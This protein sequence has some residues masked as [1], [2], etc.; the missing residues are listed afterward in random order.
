MGGHKPYKKRDK[1]IV[2]VGIFLRGAATMS[3]NTGFNFQ[4]SKCHYRC[5]LIIHRSGTDNSFA[6]KCPHCQK[7]YKSGTKMSNEKEDKE[8]N[9]QRRLYEESKRMI[10]ERKKRTEGS[11]RKYHCPKCGFISTD[12]L[13]G[14][15]RCGRPKDAIN[16]PIS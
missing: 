16:A 9:K 15:L 2:G 4:C 3:S 12:D 6:Y 5:F 8:S 10:E 1:H 7:F 11:V 14:C 13:V